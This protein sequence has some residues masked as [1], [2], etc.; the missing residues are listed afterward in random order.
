MFGMKHILDTLAV[1]LLNIELYSVG[2]EWNYR[3]NDPYSRIYLITEGS[4][5]IFHHDQEFILKPGHLY[6]IPCFTTVIMQCDESFTHYFIH[7]TSRIQTGQDIVSLL[8]CD[9]EADAAAN[10]VSPALFDRLLVLNPD[11]KLLYLRP[12]SKLSPFDLTKPLYPQI[13]TRAMKLDHEQSPP[14][15]LETN[16]LMLKLLVSFFRQCDE[17]D[18]ANTVRG[19]ARF[20]V[21][22]DF[23]RENMD[24]PITLDEMAELVDLS[25]AYFSDLFRKLIGI[26]PIHYVNKCRIETAQQLLLSTNRTLYQIAKDVGFNDVYYFSR[27]FKKAV[28]IA[29]SFYRRQCFV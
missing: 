11:R 5:R 23:V 1:E 26:S 19:L 17:S 13:L 10:D 20:R 16:S 21:V 9:Y 22:I 6:L 24:S 14:D 2:R 4:G 8:N 29:P 25:P 27:M 28:G 12:D 18:T 3:Q 7:F 15:I